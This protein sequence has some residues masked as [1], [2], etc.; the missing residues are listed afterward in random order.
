MTHLSF[1]IGKQY[2]IATL[3]IIVVGPADE[4]ATVLAL[5]SALTREQA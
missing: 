3:K 5:V 2:R 4:M 1:R